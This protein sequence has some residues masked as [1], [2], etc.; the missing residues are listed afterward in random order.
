MRVMV[1]KQFSV[2]APVITGIPQGTVLGPLLFLIYVNNLPDWIKNDMRMFADDTKIWSRNG[3]LKWLFDSRLTWT[4]YMLGQTN[5]YS[6]SIVINTRL[7]TLATTTGFFIQYNRI[8]PYNLSATTE[9]RD[10]GIVVTDNLGV[11]TQ[12]AE[13][14]KDYQICRRI[15]IISLTTVIVV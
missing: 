14:A 9:E 2:W 10:L 13:E 15:F 6:V 5:G 1:N 12:C 7:C 4:S 8:T 11:L 3:G